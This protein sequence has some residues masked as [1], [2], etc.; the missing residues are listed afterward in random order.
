MVMNEE[1]IL[2]KIFLDSRYLDEPIVG[3]S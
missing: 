1:M 2:S 3:S